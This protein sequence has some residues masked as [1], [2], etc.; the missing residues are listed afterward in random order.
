MI[1][2]SFNNDWVAGPK[3][4]AFAALAGSAAKPQPVTLPHDAIRDL[5]RSADSDQG[6]H[7][8]Y[9]SG[10][11]FTYAKTF[12]VPEDWRDKVVTLEFE[13]VYR[14]AVVFL[15]GEFAAQRPNG[16]AG[17]AVKADPYLRYGQPNTITVSAE[18]CDSLSITVYA[19]Q[20]EQTDT[21]R[22]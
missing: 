14:D 7:T 4:S 9:F 6:S 11:V 21:L 2:Q 5:P 12:D 20:L 19:E 10:G 8:G 18:G 1:R 3:V 15:N 22:R 13:G 16:Y 17:F